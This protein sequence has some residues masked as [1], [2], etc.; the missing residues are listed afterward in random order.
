MP[1]RRIA[2]PILRRCYVRDLE[3]EH[4]QTTDRSGASSI[5]GRTA[6]RRDESAL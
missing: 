6:R 1:L 3:N 2:T 4:A 5:S